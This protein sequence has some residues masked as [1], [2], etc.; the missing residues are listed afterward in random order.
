M[1]ADNHLNLTLHNGMF[2]DKLEVRCMA[3]LEATLMPE[4]HF[5]GRGI[6]SKNK[7]GAFDRRRQQRK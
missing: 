4:R 6:L 2:D 3:I 7:L 1:K 5:F